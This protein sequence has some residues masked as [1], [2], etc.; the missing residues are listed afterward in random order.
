MSSNITPSAAMVDQCYMVLRHL[1]MSSSVNIRETFSSSKYS[2]V[3]IYRR[4]YIPKGLYAQVTVTDQKTAELPPGMLKKPIIVSVNGESRVFVPKTKTVEGSI[5]DLE[6]IPGDT[7]KVTV[8]RGVHTVRKEFEGL[9][10]LFSRVI[11]HRPEIW[12]TPSR[13]MSDAVH[14]FG[15]VH[16][17]SIGFR[18]GTT[19]G[20][21]LP[22]YSNPSFV[23]CCD[24]KS[25]FDYIPASIAEDFIDQV[26]DYASLRVERDTL[27]H[28]YPIFF[29]NVLN[30]ISFAYR[31]RKKILPQGGSLTPMY[32][33]MA[34]RDNDIEMSAI[35]EET[36]SQYFRYVDNI[37]FVWKKGGPTKGFFQ[38]VKE[39]CG[40]YPLNY[41]KVKWLPRYRDGK[42]QPQ[43]VLGLNLNSDVPGIRKSLHKS[44]RS[45]MHKASMITYEIIR[46]LCVIIETNGVMG[47]CERMP[48]F[49]T[50]GKTTQAGRI[51]DHCDMEM[52][53]RLTHLVFES[54]TP[55][56][57]KDVF[58]E[59]DR[60]PAS[61]SSTSI[62][63]AMGE[64]TPNKIAHVWASL[65][66]TA[67]FIR[68]NDVF[69]EAS[70][71]FGVSPNKLVKFVTGHLSYTNGMYA[72]SKWL[73]DKDAEFL[74][75]AYNNPSFSTVFRPIN[76]GKIFDKNINFGTICVT[77]STPNTGQNSWRRAFLQKRDML[78]D[79]RSNSLPR[80]VLRLAGLFHKFST[81]L[82]IS[83]R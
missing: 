49:K 67:L 60:L 18:P 37:Y 61:R 73:S 11:N 29:R 21:V 55:L 56:F 38:R 69:V 22:E 20:C 75:Q 62:D 33:A 57:D 26:C 28:A 77:G 6:L 15:N 7:I 51:Y 50:L 82:K 39:A 45:F 16:H 58:E 17:S 78:Q 10:N 63:E 13:V 71:R 19:I 72:R 44:I 48:R 83:P 68:L 2:E 81:E 54:Y 35:A 9:S 25:Y 74:I 64:P 59:L 41:D 65:Y 4:F 80:E 14:S 66:A 30:A 40:E 5:K 31:G 36:G 76:L 1:L 53:R 3:N 70:R 27:S 43:V 34:F 46:V 24:L 12:G 47:Q 23:F 42:F 32:S 79:E 8:G 52:V